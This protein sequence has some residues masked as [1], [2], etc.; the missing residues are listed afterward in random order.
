MAQITKILNIDVAK[1]N[2]FQALVAKQFDSKSRYLK[3][4][5]QNEGVDIEVEDNCTVVMNAHRADG[6]SKGYAGSVNGDGTVTV[7]ITSWMLALD[8]VVVCDISVIDSSARKLTTLSFEIEV[9]PA[10]YSGEDI[11]EDDNYDLL[12]ALLADVADATAGVQ[13][14]TNAANQAAQR[15]EDAAAAALGA[16]NSFEH[17]AERIERAV[18]S[19]ETA[20]NTA[21]A[22]AARAEAACLK[23]EYAADNIDQEITMVNASIALKGDNLFFNEEDGKLYLTSE[24]EIVGE[25]VVVATSGGGGGGGSSGN[26]AV[27]SFT[28]T[29]G[30]LSKTIADG[31]ACSLTANWS[32]VEDGMATGNGALSIKVGGVTKQ[33][34]DVAQGDISVDIGDFLAVGANSV[35]LVIM[36]AYG[37]SRSL[38]FTISVVALSLASTFDATIPYTGAIA[39]TYIPTGNAAKT[40]HYKLDGV[41]QDT[42]VIN[43]SGRQQTYTIPAQ[44]HGS[45]TFEIWFTAEIDGQTVTSNHLFYDLM[46]IEDGK[47]APV[48]SCPFNRE[49]VAQFENVAVEWIVYNPAA[50][51][52]EVVLAANGATISTQTV[53]RTKQT[54]N[55]RPD[56]VGALTLTITCGGTVKTITTTVEVTEIE[57]EAVTDDLELHLSSYGRSNNE[58]VPASWVSGAVACS[59]SNY[60]WTS[61][62]WLLDDDGITVHRVSGDARLT[63]P[64]KLFAKDFRGTG[65]TIEIEFATRNVLNYDATILSCFSGGRGITITAQKALLKSEQS[66]I[67]TQYKENEHIRI[68]F[69]VEKR[70]E[71]R[72]IYIYINGIMSGVVQYPDD[73][74]FSQASPVD[75]S[76]GSND[77]TIDL[78]NIRVYSNNLTR[79]Q[80]LDNWIADT[81]DI[82]EKLARYGRNSIF[83]DYGSIIIAKLPSDLPYLVLQAPAL[84]AYKGNKLNVDGY[85][86]DPENA[87]KCFEFAAA[88]ADVQGTSSAGYARKNYKI[89]FKNGFTLNGVTSEGYQLRNDSIA[90]DT[91]TFKADVASSEG[92]NN[93]E[94]VRLYDKIC[95]FKTPPQLL[96]TSVRQGID[97]FPIVIFH[98]NGSGAV[99]VGKYNFN[100]DKGTPEVFGFAEG[101]ESWEIR[102][103]TSNRVLFKDADFSG[104]DWQNDFEARYP[105]DSTDVENLAAFVAWVASTDQSAATGK[106]LPASVTYGGVTYTKDTAEYRLAK[107]KAEIEDHAELESS[108][109]YYLFTEL[110]L[111][112]DSRAKNAF[113]SVLG[114]SKFCWLPY[115]MDTAIGINNEGALAFGYE[116]EDIDHTAS[117]ADVYNGQNSV[118]WINMR[119]CFYERMRSMYQQLRSDGVLS[120]DVIEKAYEEHQSKWPEAIWNEDA[121]YKYLQPLVEDN[122]A[123]YLS[124]LQGSKAEQRKWWLYNRFRYLDSKYNA[125][126]SLSDFITLRGYA[127]ADVTVEPYADIYASI[128]YGSY[129]VQ[130]R[131]LRGSTYTLGC[132]LDNVNDTEIYIYSASQLKSVGD[133]SGLKVGYAEFSLATKLQSLKL[134][135]AA[136]TYSNEN[137]TELYLGNNTLLHTLDVRNCPNLGSCEIQQSVDLSGC[138]N[139]ENVYFDGTTIKGCSLPNGGI[140][141]VLH[142]PDTITNLTIRNQTAITDFTIPGYAN[143]STL[144]LENVSAAVDSVAILKAIAANSRVRLIGVDW[145]FSKASEVENLYNILDTMRGLDEGGNNTDVAQVSGKIHVPSLTGTEL[146]SL[147]SRYTNI[148]ITY[149]TIS[150]YV[151]YK[152]ADGALL[153]T[154]TVA[155]GGNAIDPVTAGKITAPTMADTEDVKYSYNGWGTLPTNIK[156]NQTVTAQYN[157]SYAVRFYNGSTL[158]HTDWVARGGTAVYSG[159]TPTKAQTAQYTY[160]FSGWSTSSTG[161]VSSSA[162]TNVTAPRNVYA[163]FTYTVRTYTVYFYNGS[164]L[165]QTVNNVPYGSS[166]TYTGDTPVSPDGSAEDYPFEGWSPSSNNITGNTSCYAVFGSPAPVFESTDFT[167]GYGVEWDYS[168]SATTLTRIGLASG[169]SNPAPATSLTAAGS[170]P[171]D[172]VLPWSGMKRYNVIDGAIAYSEDDADFSMTDYDTVVYIPPFYYAAYKDEANTKWRWSIS[173]VEKEGYALHPGSGRY[174]GRYHTSGDSSAVFSKSGVQPLVSTSRTN[175]R[176]YSHNK[177]DNWWMIDIA[178]WSAL[179]LLFLVEFADFHSQNKL[180]KG[181]GSNSQA[182]GSTDEAVYHTYNG[183]N[184][185]NQYRWIEQPWGRCYDWVDGFMASARACYLGTNNSTFTDATTNLKAADVT[186][187]SPQYITGFGYSNKFPWAMLPDA[188]SGG[189]ASTYVPDYVYSNSGAHA[190]Y[191]GGYSS[192]SDYCG[193]FYFNANYNASSAYASLGSRLLYIP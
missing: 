126:D 171:F 80:I 73:D 193:L 139:I 43:V 94:L 31:S 188:A 45:H 36:D 137:L 16:S 127:K 55:Y 142:L 61:D 44:N 102:N 77:C 78:Y 81:Q 118:F 111:M 117:G 89:K 165:L 70:A 155:E 122:S 49:T 185:T 116:L 96:N 35:K 15:A 51:T 66:E 149:D 170:S 38:N 39:Y 131:A 119:G 23:A 158:L 13:E 11:A 50:L 12:V 87:Y 113:P 46:C 42:Q 181:Y 169:F 168:Q 108:M 132:P 114:G 4:Q 5:L 154:D 98:D 26:N 147:Q 79:Y 7:P 90:T 144:R 85:Y 183:G 53:D 24:G 69:V 146:E 95:P 124:M 100:N 135:D 175:F 141:K 74:D 82:T 67:S 152:N 20:N 156:S 30:W 3:V 17:S 109:F 145:K 128:K 174:I 148:T 121:W 10:S 190:L 130:T 161:S 29:T 37:N 162:L 129:L 84:P 172:N 166:A 34:K 125:G 103:N 180:G 120:Y 99:F 75:I 91:F 182:L 179:Q 71:N 68:A 151:Y 153:Y 167:L 62:G 115:D 104:T 88:Q 93:V 134:G 178:T 105:E 76:I 52:T 157:E 65:K 8:D 72:L 133:L 1:K 112:V 41:E 140:L 92:A 54:W 83:D 143:I 47:T 6:A 58:A 159:S 22:D 2:R 21:T 60:N 28:N 123:A 32:S 101:D 150:F 97:G 64:L 192:S 163:A 63:I 136:A 27:L 191:V 164:T 40:M 110:F 14:A 86:T 107:F 48:I 187:P 18:Q 25:G 56:D 57:V 106:S 160:T 176:T 19:I 186:L 33:T 173:P 59:F 9:D 138:T 177:G 184:T 189:S